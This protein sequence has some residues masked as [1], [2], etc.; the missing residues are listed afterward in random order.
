MPSAGDKLERSAVITVRQASASDAPP[1][2]AILKE[3]PEAAIWPE[4]SLRE[5][6]SRGIAWAAEVDG[7][8]AGL[9][10]GR[11]AADEFE[12]LNLAIRPA[13]RRKGIAA[14]LVNCAAERARAEGARNIFLE[15]RASNAGAIAFYSRMRFFQCGRRPKY[16]RDPVEDAVVLVLHI[17]AKT[18]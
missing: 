15:V 11:F 12:I 18:S 4:E 3:S 16:Y 10:V 17:D 9:I 14:R 2:H 7:D 6:I 13:L 8:V 5:A 1:L